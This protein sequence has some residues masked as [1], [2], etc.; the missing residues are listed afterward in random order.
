MH[1]DGHDR[2]QVD[3]VAHPLGVGRE[4]TGAAGPS[5]A[6]RTTSVALRWASAAHVGDTEPGDTAIAVANRQA[7]EFAAK[8]KTRYPSAVACVT[9]EMASLTVHLRFPAEHWRRI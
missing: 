1:G 4:R 3:G 8:W 2:L 9:D 7:A 6:G 5:G